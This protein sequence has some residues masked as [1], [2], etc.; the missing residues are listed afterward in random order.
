MTRL[1]RLNAILLL[2]RSKRVIRG[3][4][5]A[6]E[7]NISLRTVYRDVKSLMSS[8]IPIYSEAGYGYSLDQDYV[9]RPVQ[10]SDAEAS[11]LLLGAEFV[12]T[13]T[14]KSIQLSAKT[15]L[16]KIQAILPE[17]SRDYVER[18]S[19]RLLLRRNGHSNYS[20][21]RD[22]LMAD[23]NEAIVNQWPMAIRYFAKHNEQFTNR[24]IEPLGIFFSYNHWHVAAYC[25]LRQDYRDFRIDR[26]EELVIEKKPFKSHHDFNLNRFLDE[27]FKSADTSLIRVRFTKEQAKRLQ[28]KH[29]FNIVEESAD[30]LF[31][32][33]EFN[34]PIVDWIA[35]WILSFGVDCK[36]LKPDLLK[37][38][39]KEKSEKVAS[40]YR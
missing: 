2:L 11:A 5:I 18:L 16:Q 1:D 17:A 39:V 25:R 8:G 30:G 6:S 28:E 31:I 24:V 27:Q 34:A 40:L 9:L 20:G 21:F 4:E 19:E 33:M 13:T 12:A 37:M 15:A 7:F 10:L 38:M 3:E 29:Y 32:T 23:L 22:D 36:V 35:T 14:D 26:I